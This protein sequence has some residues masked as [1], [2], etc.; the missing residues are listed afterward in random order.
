MSENEREKPPGEPD[1]DYLW[2][3]TGEPDPEVQRLERLLSPMA[4][5]PKRRV[6]VPL[7]RRWFRPVVTVAIVA[8]AA[9]VVFLIWRGRD[10]SGGKVAGAGADAG[11]GPVPVAAAWEVTQLDGS[12]MCDSKPLPNG[13]AMLRLGDTLLTDA[14]SRAE[15]VVADKLG[16]VT[17][18]PNSEIKLVTSRKDEHRLALA[19]GV[20]DAEINAP[21]RLFWVDTPSATA[22]DYGCAYRLR[23]ND[24]GSTVLMVNAGWVALDGAKPGAPLSIVPAGARCTSRPGR[25]PGTPRFFDTSGEFRIPLDRFD[26]GD[27]EPATITELLTAARVRD[28][29]SLWHVLQRVPE[30]ERPAVIKRIL[31]LVPGLPPGTDERAVADLNA[32][33]LSAWRDKLRRSWGAAITPFESPQR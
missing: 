21:P 22:I 3:G 20:I 11:A 17:V 31:E 5:D 9:A 6:V 4:Y 29:L 10:G 13:S 16:K 8:A 18:E 7:R 12:P 27:R 33:A 28:T 23:V 30:E 24:D 15:I 26:D 14:T 19:R 1:G 25:G 32:D 2:D